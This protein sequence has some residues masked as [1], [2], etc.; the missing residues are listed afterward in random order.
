MRCR[1]FRASI[2]R[3]IAGWR[4]IPGYCSLNVDVS[5]AD[6]DTIDAWDEH[7]DACRP[8][9]EAALRARVIARGADPD[10]G[11]CA[12][13]AYHLPLTCGQCPDPLV[14][15]STILVHVERTGAYG[16]ARHDDTPSPVRGIVRIAH[17]PW[18]GT[19]LDRAPGDR[20]RPRRARSRRRPR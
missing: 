12:C 8:C 18:C 5:D 14:C 2:P 16:I 10:V 1:E 17:C 20:R 3:A 11:P 4:D 13:I 7:E 19:R 6:L 9:A 15:P